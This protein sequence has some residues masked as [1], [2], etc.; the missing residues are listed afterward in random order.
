MKTKL[1]IVTNE[2]TV[3]DFFQPEREACSY[4]ISCRHRSNKMADHFKIAR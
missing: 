2:I 1:F 4:I 3:E